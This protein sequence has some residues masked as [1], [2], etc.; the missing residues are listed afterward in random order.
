MWLLRLAE[1]VGSAHLATPTNISKRVY[2][3]KYIEGTLFH[4]VLGNTEIH[5]YCIVE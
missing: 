5:T 2:V 4:K 3:K 1:G